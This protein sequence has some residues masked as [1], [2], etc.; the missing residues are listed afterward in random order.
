[1]AGD[2]RVADEDEVARVVDGKTRGEGTHDL[3]LDG[4]VRAE[5]HRR[6]SEQGRDD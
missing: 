3:R 2:E 4:D 1:L 5:T 6:Q